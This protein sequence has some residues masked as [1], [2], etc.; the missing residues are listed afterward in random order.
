LKA[1][2]Y[3]VYG[4]E[5][6]QPAWWQ[7]WKKTRAA[8]PASKWDVLKNAIK[9]VSRLVCH[10][11]KETPVAQSK[12]FSTFQN[13]PVYGALDHTE[14]YMAA[15]RFLGVPKVNADAGP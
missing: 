4:E 7:I 13:K 5:E 15:C 10:N 9:K 2:S 1:A 6:P 12:P 3:S 8:P 11:R 14:D